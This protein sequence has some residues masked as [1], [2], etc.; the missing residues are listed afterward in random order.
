MAGFLIIDDDTACRDGMMRT[1]TDFYPGVP[2]HQADALASALAALD[3]HRDIEL[4]LLDL[5]LGDGQGIQTLEALKSW[6]ETQDC[7]P[8]VVIVSAAADADDSLIAAAIDRCATGF[9]PKGAHPAVLRSA[10][11]LTL[12]GTIYIPEAYLVSTRHS[13]PGAAGA[14]H[15]TDREVSVAELLV[16]G[17]TYK[18]IARRLSAPER[19]MADS[20]VRVHVQRIAW[21]L[22]VAADTAAA[23]GRSA[24][25]AVI[26]AL[27]AMRF[28]GRA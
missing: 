6:C 18:Q 19:P 11:D 2:L 28:R 22:R 7:N 14:A 26:T 3:Q 20:T 15:L 1:L 25:A 5:N 17:L 27:A 24:K 10:I 16:Q 23:D 21:K 8:R 4:V 13:P 12:A 9:I